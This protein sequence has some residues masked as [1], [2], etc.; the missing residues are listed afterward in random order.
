MIKL[1]L[2]LSLLFCTNYKINEVPSYKSSRV[3]LFWVDLTSP[4]ISNE[5]AEKFDNLNLRYVNDLHKHLDDGEVVIISRW[6]IRQILKEIIELEK[7]NKLLIEIL[8]NDE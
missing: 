4:R 2:I 5:D 6:K 7:Q 1:I 3:F 8:K